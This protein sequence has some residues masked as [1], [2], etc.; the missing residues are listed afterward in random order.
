MKEL[1]LLELASTILWTETTLYFIMCDRRTTYYCAKTLPAPYWLF[2]EDVC[3]CLKVKHSIH[4]SRQSLKGFIDDTMWHRVKDAYCSELRSLKVRLRAQEGPVTRH[5]DNC[6]DLHLLL[7]EDFLSVLRIT[8]N[9]YGKT[10][11]DNHD[12]D[13]DDDDDAVENARFTSINK[14]FLS[15]RAKMLSHN[16]NN[17]CS[18]IDLWN[19]MYQDKIY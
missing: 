10:A 7:G 13:D 2:I 14:C 18:D 5:I 12:D 16:D 17:Y 4:I 6:M 1:L 19:D 9:V 15:E 11:A 3:H 8:K